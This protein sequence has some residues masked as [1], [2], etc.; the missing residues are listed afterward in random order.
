MSKDIK[1][2]IGVFV[3]FMLVT[4]LVSWLIVNE[5][6]TEIEHNGGLGT[7]IG[8]FVNSIKQEIK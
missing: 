1:I 7:A 2:I 8:R 4:F 6:S 3:C 5:I